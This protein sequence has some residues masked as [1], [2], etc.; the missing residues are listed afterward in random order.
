MT[1]EGKGAGLQDLFDFYYREYKPLYSRV[2]AENKLAQ[3][4]LFEVAAAFDHAAR[5]YSPNASPDD[6]ESKCA[7]EAI[8]HLK[9]A[10]LD[11]YKIEYFDTKEVYDKLCK[12]PIG[13][14]DNGDYEK[15]LRELFADTK[16]M[17]ASARELEG[18]RQ[19][20]HPPAFDI[21]QNISVN[22]ARIMSKEFYLHPSVS[23]AKRKCWWPN[24]VAIIGIV[25]GLLGLLATLGI[26]PT[27]R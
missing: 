22:C 3:E 5:C 27:L 16:K 17:T 8:S 18:V 20:G 1:V 21:W 13:F 10:C 26:I 25:L 15:K 2:S 7:S 24:W 23:W 6:S 14:I 19:A 4:A 9:R 11:M 12:L